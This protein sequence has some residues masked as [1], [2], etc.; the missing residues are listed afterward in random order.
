MQI[1]HSGLRDGIHFV[2]GLHFGRRSFAEGFSSFADLSS[3]AERETSFSN[4]L[5][6][7]GHQMGLEQLFYKIHQSN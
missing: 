3:E 1:Y 5:W 6:E 4:Y 7:R 2:V